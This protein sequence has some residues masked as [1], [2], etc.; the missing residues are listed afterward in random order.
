MK[1]LPS[2]PKMSFSSSSTLSRYTS[3]QLSMRRPSLVSG[4]S[5]TPGLVMSRKNSV[6]MDSSSAF[7]AMMTRYFT[8][9]EEVMK[10]LVPLR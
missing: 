9:A 2:L 6:N 5:F 3:Q 4:D 8:P 10:V 7:L 1:P